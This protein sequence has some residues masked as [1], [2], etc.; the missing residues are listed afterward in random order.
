MILAEFGY[1]EALL[2]LSYSFKDRAVHPT[3]WWNLE[4]FEKIER[5]AHRLA[6]RDGGHN[7]F[8]ESMVVWIDIEAPRFWWSEFDT[9][10]V[11]TTKQSESTMHTVQK[12]PL[13]Q[14][15]FE[16]PIPDL[17][18]KHLNAIR[19]QC[20]VAEF[21]AM[22]PDGYKQRRVVTTNYK[23]LRNIIQQRH[24]HRLPQWE[25]FCRAVLAQLDHP[26]M[27]PNPFEKVKPT[28]TGPN[29]TVIK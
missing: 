25:Q 22:L 14:D 21:K 10:R 20:S 17:Y 4:R 23:T 29:L 9:Y 26:E 3:D 13:T 18:L 19:T 24:D 27:L 8:L 1:R 15:D 28:N 5:T 7:K 16:I 11:G 12:R 2:G 6:F